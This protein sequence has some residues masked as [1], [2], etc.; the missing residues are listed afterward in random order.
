MSKKTLG[1]W[2]GS[3]DFSVI[4]WD[5]AQLKQK[6]IFVGHQARVTSIAFDPDGKVIASAGLDQSIR[7]WSVDS[8]NA[9]AKID[10]H[11]GDVRAMAFSPDGSIIASGVENRVQLW[12]VESRSFAGRLEES[13]GLIDAIAFRPDAKELA[14]SVGYT[15]SSDPVEIPK[16]QLWDLQSLQKIGAIT[17]LTTKFLSVAYSPDD[18]MLAAGTRAETIQLWDLKSST[19]LTGALI[20][21]ERK[22]VRFPGV[23]ALDFSPNSRI[24]ATGGGDGVVRLWDPYKRLQLAILCGECAGRISSVAFDRSGDMLIVSQ[25]QTVHFWD[26]NSRAEL[27]EPFVSENRPPKVAMSPHTTLLAISDGDD[28]L[29]WEL[30]KNEEIAR[31]RGLPGIVV[32]S[33]AF[34]PNG[35]LLAAAFTDFSV[36]VW[37]VQ[38]LSQIYALEMANVQTSLAFSR[39]GQLLV[40]GSRD[41]MIG[42]WDALSGQKVREL[43][44]HTMEV[45]GLAFTSTGESLVS[46]SRDGTLRVW[47][48]SQPTA[49]ED[50]REEL[51]V[52]QQTALSPPYPN[53]SNHG[54]WFPYQLA[55]DSDVT[56]SVFNISGQLV[57]TYELGWKTAGQY[58]QPG[59]AAHWNG[60]DQQGRELASGVYVIRFKAEE[61]LETR[62]LLLLR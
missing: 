17:G 43:S 37:T 20:G 21:H 42:I 60:K 50:A 10:S 24:L 31:L 22:S 46:A 3:E 13:P 53:P 23:G 57:K 25:G 14:V 41:G 56:L 40:S 38:N 15:L 62:K 54:V 58:A 11:E 29:L 7:L 16:V 59:L 35:L 30:L 1:R 34:G 55:N 52:P 9:M 32:Q 8:S 61:K 2:T 28:I 12:D 48:S 6:A 44:G 5:I 39:N 18:S 27:R 19:K 45:T 49:V 33:L 4:L 51:A 47:E 36:R 26:V